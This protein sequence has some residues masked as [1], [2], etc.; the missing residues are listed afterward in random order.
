[1]IFSLSLVLHKRGWLVCA[2]GWK[3]CR[4]SASLLARSHIHDRECVSFSRSINEKYSKWIPY[5]WFWF[6]RFGKCVHI[7]IAIMASSNLHAGEFIN[8]HSTSEKIF[9][10]LCSRENAPR[11]PLKIYS[12]QQRWNIIFIASSL[13]PHS[14]HSLDII[15]LNLTNIYLDITTS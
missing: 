11:V 10:C 14:T 3:N 1:M 7:H 15:A 12:Q 5:Q 6:W 13:S 9:G 8:I 2:K 4:F